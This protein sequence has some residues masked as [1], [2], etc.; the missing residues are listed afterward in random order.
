MFFKRLKSVSI[1]K[2]IAKIL[3]QR[4]KDFR[5]SKVQSVGIIF[6]YEAYHDYDFFHGLL[7]ELGI[8]KNNIRFIAK[9]D[10]KKTHP[11]SWDS[12]YSLEDFDW[13]GKHKNQ[14]IDEFVDQPFDVLIS[15]Y[16]TNTLD[17]NLITALTKANFK[18]GLNN[19]DDRLHDFIIEVDPSKTDIFKIELIKYLTTLNRL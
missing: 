2:N 11:N 9:I 3:N 4:F 7:K 6:D 15:Y 17:L 8:R 10:A 1:K 5:S 19:E 12:F 13:L 16:K 18:L 14:E